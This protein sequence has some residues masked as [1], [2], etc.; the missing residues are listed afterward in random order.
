MHPGLRIDADAVVLERWRA[1]D[2]A[3]LLTAVSESVDHLRPWMAWAAAPPTLAS[4]DGFI[5][6]ST[7]GFDAGT[8]FTYAIREPGRPAILGGCGLHGRRR[9][10]VLEIGYW[11]HVAHTRRGLATAAA[12][13]LARS[14][15]ALPHIA[16]VEIHCD[17]ANAASAGVAR[18]LGFRL[19]RVDDDDDVRTPAQTGRSMIWALEGDQPPAAG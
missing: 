3:A 9:A 8:E 18:R 17:A 13:A 15:L 6:R 16:R 14:A 7:E 2:A 5:V 11:V 4:S 10:G 19:D 12:G 1:G